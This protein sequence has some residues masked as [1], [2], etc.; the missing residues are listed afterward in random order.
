[1][2]DLFSLLL[3]ILTGLTIL[4]MLLFD[5]QKFKFVY[6][7]VIVLLGIGVYFHGM[8]YG[9][10]NPNYFDILLRSV[11]NTSQILRG[12]FQTP[13]ISERI[14]ADVYFLVSAYAIHVIGF[15]YT[16]ILIFAIFFKNLQLKM[17][18]Q[19]I[20]QQSHYLILTDSN[21]GQYVL[22]SLTDK[23][24]VRVNIALTK[25]FSQEKTLLTDGVL[26]PGVTLYDVDARPLNEILPEKS[27][28][29]II[30]FSLLLS[31]SSTLALVEKL[32]SWMTRFPDLSLQVYVLFQ[33]SETLKV[34][35]TL[36]QGHSKIHFF[37]YHQLVARQMLFDHPL[38][39]LVPNLINQDL[40]TLQGKKVNYNIIGFGPTNR[41]IYDHLLVTNQFPPVTFAKMFKLEQHPIHYGIYSEEGKE[42][43]SGQ[44]FEKPKEDKKAHYLPYPTIA[45]STDFIATKLSGSDLI[46]QFQKQNIQTSHFN[47]FIIAGQTD[48]ENLNIA[49]KVQEFVSKNRLQHRVKIFVQI[50]NE[51]LKEASSLFKHEYMI[52]FGFGKT[53]YAADQITE[54]VFKQLA[55]N[56]YHGLFENQSFDE[57][58]SF[59]QETYFF[60]AI[61][62]RFKLNLMGLDLRISTRGLSADEFYKLYDP[63]MEGVYDQHDLRAK[64]YFDIQ[65]YKRLG[66]HKR[67]LLARQEQLRF[68]A[69]KLYTGWKQRSLEDLTQKR[70]LVDERRREDSRITT[71]EGLLELHG[72]LNEKLSFSFQEADYIYPLF[73]T[74]DHLYQFIES[75][76]YRVVDITN[77]IKNATMEFE[78]LAIQDG[79][80]SDIKN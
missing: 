48:I 80:Q 46:D 68:A 79:L 9:V 24:A 51:T 42:F 66:N 5:L 30:F 3:L 20:K 39:S 53:T 18:F 58:S 22:D 57:L 63:E 8:T 16:Y 26:K 45:S 28:G 12:I 25:K 56:I 72:I 71:F 27:K 75:T 19:S 50:L 54:P 37:S 52:A 29:K 11:G 47:I 13:S 59:D 62:I 4:S 67:N 23:K 15:G 44:R 41:E 36:T 2:I 38:T 34:L 17:R 61:A 55:Q 78:Q 74:M 10:E 65:K 70:V 69:Y 60:E 1:M 31:E 21:L 76:D 40:V 7:G 6:L 14:N 33:S 77:D 73:H 32:Q 49:Y 43:I 35:E 64:N